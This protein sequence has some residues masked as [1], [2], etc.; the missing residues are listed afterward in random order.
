MAD[1]YQISYSDEAFA[2]LKA[3][4]IY[5]QRIVLDAIQVHLSFEPTKDSRSRIKTMAQ[6]FWSQFRLR[7]NDFRV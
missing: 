5:D 4:R 2:D 6:P 3:L 1:G 7:V